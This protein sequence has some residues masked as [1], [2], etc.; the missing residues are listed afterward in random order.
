[1][2][3]Y[4]PMGD[5]ALNDFAKLIWKWPPSIDRPSKKSRK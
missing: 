3:Q 1:M 5:R 4:P 2:K